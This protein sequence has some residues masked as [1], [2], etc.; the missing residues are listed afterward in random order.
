MRYRAAGPLDRSIAWVGGE[1][2]AGGDRASIYMSIKARCAWLD[3]APARTL[4]PDSPTTKAAGPWTGEASRSYQT[5]VRHTLR[6]IGP[7]RSREAVVI[8]FEAD[9]SPI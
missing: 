1:G 2:G 4:Q 6:V 3:H 9:Q 5:S 8:L 7:I